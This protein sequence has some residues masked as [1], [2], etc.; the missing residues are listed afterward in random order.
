LKYG[1]VSCLYGLAL[2]EYHG[3]SSP[4]LKVDSKSS[5]RCLWTAARVV[6]QSAWKPHSTRRSRPSPSDDPSLCAALNIFGGVGELYQRRS[7]IVKL[8]RPP[9]RQDWERAETAGSGLARDDNELGSQLEET[10]TRITASWSR[11]DVAH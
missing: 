10:I 5:P 7:V 1:L 6:I 4:W 11:R 9:S 3:A 8:F 2:L